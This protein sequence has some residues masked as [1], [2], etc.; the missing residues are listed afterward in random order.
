MDLIDAEGEVLITEAEGAGQFLMY[1]VIRVMYDAVIGLTEYS[2]PVI[3]NRPLLAVWIQDGVDWG[4]GACFIDRIHRGP[5]GYNDQAI[6]FSSNS[7]DRTYWSISV[8]L[9]E[10]GH[11]V[12]SQF[13]TIP[14][15][16]GPHYLGK[17]TLPGQAWAE[18]FATLF[19]ALSSGESIYYRSREVASF[20]L[21]SMGDLIAVIMVCC[22]VI[23]VN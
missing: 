8:I 15:E 6:V 11:W 13:G 18:G 20:G 21:T 7:E 16:G 23:L 12:H 2:S 4:C 3:E 5:L 17:P 19:G 14:F 22:V 9:H 10:F 1:S